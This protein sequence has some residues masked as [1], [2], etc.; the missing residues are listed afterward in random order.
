MSQLS[1]LNHQSKEH[2][3]RQVRIFSR[4]RQLIYAKENAI[5]GG[6]DLRGVWG[7]VLLQPLFPL[8]VVPLLQLEILDHVR[9]SCRHYTIRSTY[10]SMHR[11]ASR[12]ALKQNK[13]NRSNNRDEVEWEIHDISDDSCWRKLLKGRL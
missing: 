7:G 11:I 13:K 6:A 10:A 3:Y 8:R 4:L 1:W 2:P 9:T 12:S 5:H